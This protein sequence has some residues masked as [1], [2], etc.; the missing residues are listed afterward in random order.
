MKFAIVVHHIVC[1][2]LFCIID[3]DN[4]LLSSPSLLL[5][6]QKLSKLKPAQ[7]LFQ[8]ASQK[9]QLSQKIFQVRVSYQTLLVH[10]LH[11]HK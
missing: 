8:K 2:Y 1:T 5:M 10:K 3:I 4:N 7:T 9:L 6:R 11:R